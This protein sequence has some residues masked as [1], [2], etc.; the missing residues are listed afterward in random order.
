[1]VK[2]RKTVAKKNAYQKSTLKN[3][4]EMGQEIVPKSDLEIGT[5]FTHQSSS[6]EQGINKKQQQQ[7]KD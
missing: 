3:Q 2:G 6:S 7:K 4:E 5:E 1:M